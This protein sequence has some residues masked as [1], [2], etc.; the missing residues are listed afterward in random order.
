M[1]GR[2]GLGSEII[3]HESVESLDY[4]PVPAL[5]GTDDLFTVR[6]NKGTYFARTVV[7][8]VGAGN[9]PTT[10]PIFPQQGHDAACHALHLRPDKPMPAQ[11]RTKIKA[12]KPTH[13]A[14]IG[15]GLTS[16]QIADLAIRQGVEKVWL[17]MRGHMRVKPF[18]VDLEWMG[19]FRNQMKAEFWMADGDQG[20]CALLLLVRGVL[21]TCG[22]RASGDAEDGERRGEYYAQVCQGVAE[23]C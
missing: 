3:R 6:T 12:R 7:L 15:G 19:K 22:C 9:A 14:V 4:G 11:L 17:I 13:V 10:P 5:E 16:A 8:A 23:A 18:D 2:Y 1:V 20:T 21:L